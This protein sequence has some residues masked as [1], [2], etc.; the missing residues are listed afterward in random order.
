MEST[1]AGTPAFA[2]YLDSYGMA[3]LDRHERTGSVDDLDAAVRTMRQSREAT[4]PDSAA[5]AGVL[6]NLGHALWSRHAYHPDGADLDDALAAFGCAV[7]LTP[8]ASPDAAVYRDNLANAL[9]DRFTR[10]EDPADLDRA[11]A[12][13]EA[14]LAGP[15]G[16]VERARIEANLAVALL[17]RYRRAHHPPDLDRAV[18]ILDGVVERTPPTSPVLTVRLNNLG[19]ALHHRGRRDSD[20]GEVDRAR[21]VLRRACGRA[22]PGDTR[23]A[24]AA[25]GTLAGW[26]AEER[27]WAEAADAYRTALTIAAD[28]TGVQ[29]SRRSTSAVLAQ[30]R[31]L[32][33]DAA[34]ALS[35][36]GARVEAVVAAERGRAVLLGRALA[37]DDV[38][39]GR[40][41]LVDPRLAERFRSAADRLGLLMAWADTAQTD[42]VVAAP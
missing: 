15:S 35:R 10:G 29:L 16:D 36:A 30:L 34:Y 28:Y 26:A 24:L 31:P 13:Y 32:S 9:A 19:V 2:S 4:P 21:A 37:L 11:V 3:L 40:L 39:V 38:A 22:S 23:W 42:S 20:R 27:Q 41:A 17:T 33:A 8:T 12:G 1:A 25:A 18:A 7:E 6:N 5:F 14:A